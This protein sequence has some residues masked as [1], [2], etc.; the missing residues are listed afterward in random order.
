MFK[1][2]QRTYWCN[3]RLSEYFLGERCR[4]PLLLVVSAVY[5]LKIL[6]KYIILVPSY[7]SYSLN[8]L[9]TALQ[10]AA[11][12][13]RPRTWPSSRRKWSAASESPPSPWGI[14]LN[15]NSWQNQAMRSHWGTEMF[16]EIGFWTCPLEKWSVVAFL[17]FWMKIWSNSTWVKKAMRSISLGILEAGRKINGAVGTS[18][19]PGL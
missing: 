17:D 2:V 5:N 16:L 18:N 14:Y 1:D 15:R 13:R 8:R 9:Q 19:L 6:D 12:R 7:F 4:A 11:A 10:A 3:P